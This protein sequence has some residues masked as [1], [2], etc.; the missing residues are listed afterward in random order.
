MA[1]YRE[2]KRRW[3]TKRPEK[4]HELRSA[5]AGRGVDIAEARTKRVREGAEGA[6]DRPVKKRKGKKERL[7]EKVAVPGDAADDNGV[8]A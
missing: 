4:L 7:K 1:P 8:K 5:L 3:D 2:R 6:A